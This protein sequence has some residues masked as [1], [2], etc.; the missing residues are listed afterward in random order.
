MVV[1][2]LVADHHFS[3]CLRLSARMS[4]C[5]PLSALP[6]PF[7]AFRDVLCEFTKKDKAALVGMSL[8]DKWFDWLAQ[9]VW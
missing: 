8:Q 7:C 6:V 9:S 3:E 4:L 5:P 1:A 2:A